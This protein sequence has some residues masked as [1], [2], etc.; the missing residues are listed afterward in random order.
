MPDLPDGLPVPKNDGDGISQT[1]NMR[2]I[3]PAILMEQDTFSGEF[4]DIPQEILDYLVQIGR[5]TPLRRAAALEHHL[6]TPAKIYYKREDTIVTGSFK[7][8]T[9]IAQ[10]YYCKLAGYKH[11]VSETGAGQW[12]MALALACKFF[13]LKCTIF[14]ARCSYLQKPYRKYYT[15]VLGADIYPSPSKKTKIGQSLLAED[16]NHVGS[17]GTAISD[18]I[19]IALDS[20][21]IAYLSG[22]NVPHV[23]IHQSLLGLETKKQLE[24]VEKKPDQLVACVSGGSNLAGL[25]MPFLKD[26]MNGANI[27]MLGVE[28]T[29]APRLTKGI[30]DYD[31]SDVA[32]HTP[33]V[34]SYTMGPDFIPP[35]VH[36][37]G[38]RQHN[39]SP[40]I[41][42][43]CRQGLLNA[44]AYDEYVAFDAGKLFLETEGVLVAPE[45]SHAV[46]A[47]LNSARQARETGEE[48]I[49][50][51]LCSGNGFLDLEGYAEI[52]LGSGE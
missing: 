21:E 26:K 17:I 42:H 5:P 4:I 29:A 37:G 13:G 11:V 24:K 44:V 43:L 30:Y 41:G 50:V 20:R 7:M 52:I 9:A 6:D 34:K 2:K 36:V 48:K 25:M 35:P 15:E 31:R 3:R 49:I 18:A 14:M 27:D 12:G 45:S 46:A 19:E 39:G 32:G 40:I 47:V 10:A 23:L 16:P 38:L 22:S 8:T 1:E 33:L 28:S 51:F